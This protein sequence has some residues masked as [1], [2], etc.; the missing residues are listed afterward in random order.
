MV[1]TS[2]PDYHSVSHE[3]LYYFLPFLSLFISHASNAGMYENWRFGWLAYHPQS[4]QN[5]RSIVFP[6]RVLLSLYDLSFSDPVMR[7]EVLAILRMLAEARQVLGQ[8]P[9]MLVLSLSWR[10]NEEDAE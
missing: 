10:G 5:C 7:T 8:L 4:A 6:L 2:A 9:Y 3:V 1:L